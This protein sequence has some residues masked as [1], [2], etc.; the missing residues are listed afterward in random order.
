MKIQH[1]PGTGSNVSRKC[2]IPSVCIFAPI[3]DT[4]TS[5]NA[6]N[7]RKESP[8]VGSRGASSGFTVIELVIT[9]AIAAFFLTLAVPSLR[10]FIQ[11][12]RVTTQTNDFIA[13]L[14]FVRTEAVKRAANVTM[15][16]SDDTTVAEPSCSTAGS[17]WAIGRIIFIDADLNGDRDSAEELLR[18]REPLD[19]N[20]TLT[21][22]DTS[23]GG[24]DAQ[25]RIVYTGAG[26]TTIGAAQTATFNLCDE[27]G[28]S[29]G[30]A[31]SVGFRGTVTLTKPPAG[32]T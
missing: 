26:T 16:K 12:A 13:D 2:C 9:V 27:R 15:C 32:C 31:I 10:T 7:V 25:D 30:R 21:V 18:V 11:N 6:P 17:D 19:G 24:T 22:N 8:L 3:V 29:F 20:N 14:N 1:S 5:L 4:E 28:A 23:A